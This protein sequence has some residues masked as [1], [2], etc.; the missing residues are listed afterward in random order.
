MME[1]GPPLNR[2][3]QVFGRDYQARE[4]R[5]PYLSGM[6]Q[7]TGDPDLFPSLRAL[8][9]EARLLR[10]IVLRRIVASGYEI[11]EKSLPDA[12]AII[13]WNIGAL[14]AA[15]EFEM[16]LG[17]SP[18]EDR[19]LTLL[20]QSCEAEI[21]DCIGLSVRKRRKARVRRGTPLGLVADNEN[22]G[23]FGNRDDDA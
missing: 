7:K 9:E 4:V 15:P 13:S 20:V 16:L 21:A 14:V 2:S 12:H 18:G 6:I 22:S 3:Y 17:Y 11:D 8:Y 23:D 10:D 19:I 5:R 1:V